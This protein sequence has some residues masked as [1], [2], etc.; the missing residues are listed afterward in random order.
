MRQRT[1]SDFFWRDPDISDLSQEDKAT[2]LYFLTSPSSNIIGC[3][4][5]V[6]MIA[7]AEMGWTKDQLLVVLK[8]LQTKDLIDFNESGWVWVRIWWKH[9]SP[10]GAFSPKL[11]QNAKKQISSIPEAWIK[12]FGKSL[13]QVGINTLSIGYP[14]G[15]DTVSHT[16]SHTLSDT[17]S[18]TLSENLETH[19]QQGLDTLYDT[20]SY[21]LPHRVGGNRYLVSKTTT[22]PNP[23]NDD[24][25]VVVVNDLIFP[26]GIPPDQQD[27]IR[28]I[29]FSSGVVPSHWQAILDELHGAQLHGIKTANPITNPAGY[30]RGITKRAEDGSFVPERGLPIASQRELQKNL[31]QQDDLARQADTAH[32]KFTPAEFD[33]LPEATRVSL[34]KILAF[35]TKGVAGA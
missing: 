29:L 26:P 27:A 31:K 6:W 11:L 3:Y 12:E 22:T 25:T 9:N 5:V 32:F 34:N 2:L 7:A 14:Y 16:P 19:S 28:S 10:S 4:Q 33:A 1:I 21:T 15:I 17:V 24:K 13:E 35:Q 20:P 8:R 18:H 30:V 23:S